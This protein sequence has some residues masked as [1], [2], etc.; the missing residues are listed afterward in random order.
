MHVS[1]SFRRRAIALALASAYGWG[2]PVVFANPTGAQVVHG[3]AT[4]QA[5]GSKLTVTNTP[6]AI[7]NWQ[8]F[9][10]GA[11]ETTFFQQQNAASAVLNRVQVQNPNLKSQIDGALGSN[12]RV[13]LINPNG[14]VFG[15]GS[16]IDTQGFVAST[17]NLND[18]D[19]KA[20]RLRFQRQ[21]VAGDLQ[22]AGRISS[23]NGDVYLVAPNIGI[24]G[25]A[26]ITSEGGNVV[27]AAGEMVEI[28]GRNLNDIKFAVQGKDNQVLNLGT[29]S[30]GA[31]GL[32]A[33]TLTHSG[34]AQAQSLARDGGR[35]VL[36]GQGNVSL[37][38]NSKTVADGA[39]QGGSIRIESGSGNVVVESGAQVSAQSTGSSAAVL[40]LSRGGHISLKAGSGFIA[41]E[42]DAVVNASGVTGGDVT[43]QA[44]KVM[45]D[46]TVSADGRA[47]SGGTITVQAGSRLIQTASAKVSALGVT[48]GGDIKLSVDASTDGSGFFFSSANIDASASRGTGGSVTLTGRDVTLAAARVAANGDAGGGTILVGGERGGKDSSVAHAGNIVANGASTLQASARVN[49]DGGTVVAWADGSNRFAGTLEAR[50]GAK[51]G[52][53]GFIEVSG[54]GETQFGGMADAGA[55]HGVGGSFL[56]DPKF[57]LIQAPVFIPGVS[58]ELLDPNPGNNDVFG[59]V[60]RPLSSTGNILVFN[61]ADDFAATDSG[62]IYMYNGTTGALISSL[63]GSAAN[64][65]VGSNSNFL[66][67]SN[68]FSTITLTDGSQLLSSPSWNGSAGAITIFNPATGVS[69]AVSSA[70]SLLGAA[71]NDQVGSGGI[72]NLGGNKL[73]VLSPN[74]NAT[75]GAITWYDAAAGTTGVV[76][77]ANSLI[78]STATDRVGNGGIVQLS[79]NKSYVRTAAWNSSAS[80]VTFLDNSAL[81][82][83]AISA[84]NSLVGGSPSDRIGN[85]NI[86]DLGSGKSLVFSPDWNGGMGAVTWFDQVTGTVGVVGAANSL[87]GSTPGDRV[88]SNYW[89]SVGGH[90]AIKSPNWNNGGSNALAGAITWADPAVAMTGAISSANSLVGSLANDNVGAGSIENLD[91]VHY[92]V[93]SSG[94]N[95]NAG[96]VTW[97]DTSVT[98]LVVGP[99]TSGNSLIGTS[100][101]DQVGNGGVASA[102]IG[103]SM[104]FSPN[105]NGNRGAVTW[106]DQAAGTFGLVNAANS[107]VGSSVGD[108]VGSGSYDNLAS[109]VAIF[110]PNWANTGTVPNAGAITW[111]DATTGIVGVVSAA[112]SL[113]GSNVG[114][115]VGNSGVEF[116]DGTHFAVRT[117]TWNANAGAVT[118][119]DSAAPVVSVLS[120]SNSLVGAGPGDRIGSQLINLSNGKS[121]VF[122]PNWN[123]SRGAVTWF[124]NTAGTV[125][126]VGAGNSLVGS[127]ASDQ[128]GG[129]GNYGSVGSK[130]YLY[131]PNWNNSGNTVAAGAITWADSLVGITGAVSATNSLVG[132]HANDRVGNNGIQNLDGIH[133]VVLTP[134]WNG[135]AGAVTWIDSAAP[136]VGAIDNVNS[137]VGGT[138]LDRVAGSGFFNLGTGTSLVLSPGWNGNMGAV[139]WFNSLTGTFGTVDATNSLVGSTAGTSATG[140]RV[141][142]SSYQALDGRIAIRSPNWNNGAATK[143]G[144]ITFASGPIVGVVSASNSLVGSSTNDLVGNS[145]I[146]SLTSEQFYVANSAWNGNTGAV[147]FVDVTGTMPSGPISAA[148][149]LMGA[150]SGDAVGSGGIQNLFNGKSLVLSPSW[151]GGRGAVTWFNNSTGTLGTVDATNS[152]VGSTAGDQV[153]S[154]GR[155][156]IGSGTLGIL[157]PNWDNG[158]AVDAGAITWANS[159][160]GITGAVSAAN[161]LV[162]GSSS[163]RVGSSGV[164][165]VNGTNSA[166]RTTSWNSGAGAVTWLSNAAPLTGVVGAGNSLVGSTA[167]DQVGSGGFRYGSEYILVNSNSWSGHRGA[168]T[169]IDPGAPLTGA[170]TS[171]NSLV[172]ANPNDFVGN[173]GVNFLSN[174]N[175]YVLSPQFNGGAGAVSVGPSVGGISGVISGANSLVGQSASDGYGNSVSPLFGGSNLLVTAPNADSNGLTNNGRVH[176]YS[177][178]AGGG[179]GAAGAL[180]TQTYAS[181]PSASVTITPAQITA[182]TNTG[183]AVVLQANSDITLDIASD[184]ISNNRSGRGGNLTLQAGRSVLL[185]SSIVTDDGDLTIIANDRA[186]NGVATAFR[187]AGVADITMANGTRLDAGTGNVVVQL[188]DGAGRTGEQASS[189]TIT[190]RSMVANDL[191]VQTD[192]GGIKVGDAAATLAS[193][194]RLTGKAELIAATTV[195]FAG[196][197]DGAYAQLSADGQVSINSP[198]L[199]MSNG[200][201]YARIVNSTQ[202]YP[203]LLTVSQCITC[204]TVSPY[205]ITGGDDRL[206]EQVQQ[207]A[208][209]ILSLDPIPFSHEDDT[210]KS[211]GDIEVDAGSTCK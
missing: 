191:S 50:G 86:Y 136:T 56:L 70:N 43:V 12:G 81:P 15:A 194:I 4:L 150:A 66:T 196:G 44:A 38:A 131:S 110:S 128:V 195:L 113:V 119:I 77:G 185:N 177:G 171:T 116:L 190:L 120:A 203:L 106:Y 102:G 148:N 27:L 54:R 149:S 164:E 145:F 122:S 28:T 181:G 36:S 210:K 205:G 176:L 29:L 200:G 30:G 17:L 101:N 201:S 62:A 21:G 108:Q 51:S 107:L 34:V 197:P 156:T 168:V 125:G 166:V 163:D 114:D 161:S 139:T 130:I 155:T 133:Y 16:T 93:V 1:R 84:A 206:T 20:G 92:A 32:F 167:N 209:N 45:Q 26:V 91:G 60:V 80:A 90:I 189:G 53:G 198:S 151:N 11:G 117:S 174:G 46:G 199:Q 95:N 182:I 175:Y 160:N 55:P 103:K 172:G 19:F 170:V 186:A 71:A 31:V 123:G 6:G 78:G 7:I 202:K 100:T 111:A 59:S 25:R 211:K 147:T 83:G 141:G 158:A 124:D 169:W 173:S 187:D 64:D 10:I 183:T 3:Q 152:L 82:V 5:Q 104:V 18:A 109:K 99:I 2:A 39:A 143:A 85:G 13:F 154:S 115:R 193:D 14:I 65:R 178:G 22:A 146:Q 69:G 96:A 68:F 67:T 188:R 135:S 140:D 98:P 57:I 184:I 63:R 72:Y 180:G 179:G 105:W 9:S 61:P 24:D 37:G 134:T 97:I 88:G 165:F 73:A 132:T 8:S 142:S 75:A 112:N 42:R 49:G 76:S 35:L 33:G 52:N 79:T 192:F 94:W 127:T 40:A 208:T 87:V 207:V 41:M 118:W 162:G 159:F 58:V 23:A 138:A 137:L 144:A 157:S 48:T 126:V 89:D 153:G 74:W 129:F 204:N 121:L 47:S